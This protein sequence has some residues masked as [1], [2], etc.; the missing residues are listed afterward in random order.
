MMLPRADRN[1]E[2]GFTLVEMLVALFIFSLLSVSTMT[3]LNSSLRSKEAVRGHMSA[4]QNTDMTRTL[5]K[6]DLHNL[7][8]RPMRDAYG[9]EE[10]YLLSGGAQTL[11]EF[12]RVGRMNPEGLETRGDLQRVSYVFED[13]NL[14][15]RSAGQVNPAPQT[16]TQER[17]LLSGLSGAR[18]EF[19]IGRQSQPQIFITKEP[20]T[21]RLSA[22]KLELTFENGDELSQYFEVSL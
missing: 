18:V 9:T 22:M 10:F 12:T 5:M 7:V 13:G 21:Q 4:L 6:S 14:I 17:V 1:K 20:D 16:K 11:L 3:V 8:L 15:R 2:A 19:L